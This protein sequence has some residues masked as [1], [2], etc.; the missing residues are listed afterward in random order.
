ME[1]LQRGQF[2]VGKV[3]AITAM[4]VFFRFPGR[5][6]RTAGLLRSGRIRELDNSQR[7]RLSGLCEIN[8]HV[9]VQVERWN[10]EAEFYELA[11]HCTEVNT[12]TVHIEPFQPPWATVQTAERSLGADTQIV[13]VPWRVPTP[14]SD[15]EQTDDL[16]ISVSPE[17]YPFQVVV[18]SATVEPLHLTEHGVAK[19]PTCQVPYKRGRKATIPAMVKPIETQTTAEPTSVP[20]APP[21]PAVPA[22]PAVSATPVAARAMVAVAAVADAEPV[23][24]AKPQ[25]YEQLL[26]IQREIELLQRKAQAIRARDLEKTIDSIHHT[27]RAYGIS[28]KDLC[29]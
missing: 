6:R 12:T 23:V 8:H 14:V 28:V 13:D 18:E 21:V 5:G 17:S 27:M 4:G 10:W 20:A 16:G 3:V 24:V 26:A 7:L 15:V 19:T 22:V 11:W 25:P 9:R 1:V 29:D 2:A